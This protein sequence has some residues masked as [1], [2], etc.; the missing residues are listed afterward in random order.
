MFLDAV[1]SSFADRSDQLPV[2]DSRHLSREEVVG[3]FCAS[4]VQSVAGQTVAKVSPSSRIR[5][6]DA[7]LDGFIRKFLNG[8]IFSA[9]NFGPSDEIYA[10]GKLL[11]AVR[12]TDEVSQ[13]LRYDVSTL[14]RAH[15]AAKYLLFRPLW[16]LQ[17]EFRYVAALG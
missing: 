13:V 15:S 8:H 6:P 1:P 5:V 11:A 16:H 17:Q 4:F 3:P 2:S 12:R 9:G 14:F 10:R 7:V